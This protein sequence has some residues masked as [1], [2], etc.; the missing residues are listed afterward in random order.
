[1]ASG[2]SQQR[3]PGSLTVGKRTPGFNA[4]AFLDSAGLSKTIVEYGRSEAIFS[5]GDLCDTVMYTQKGG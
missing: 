3:A 4:Q 5:Q 1:M 2:A